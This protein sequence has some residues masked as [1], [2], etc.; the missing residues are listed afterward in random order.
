MDNK[1]I[2]PNNIKAVLFD[3]DGTLVNT[4]LAGPLTL[5]RYLKSFGAEITKQE[6]ELFSKIWF[7]QIN[8]YDQYEWISDL[9]KTYEI[10]INSDDFIQGFYDLLAKSDQLP[11]SEELM[12]NLKLNKYKIGLVT[13]SSKSQANNILDHNKW[14]DYFDLIITRE[15]TVNRKPDSEPYDL[16]VRQLNLNPDQIL[17]FEDTS[18]G[19]KSALDAGCYSVGLEIGNKYQDLSNA[20]IVLGDLSQVNL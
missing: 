2:I 6:I 7:K 4:E 17:V 19:L 16:A 9:G 15:D 5:K 13:N 14:N 20:N 8:C 3:M 12:K 10:N 18:H 1:F 11:C